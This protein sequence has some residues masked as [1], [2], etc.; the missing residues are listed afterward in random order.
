MIYLKAFKNN[1]AIQNIFLF[2]MIIAFIGSVLSFNWLTA[3]AW[4]CC[5][6]VFI[7]YCNE[8]DHNRYISN[9]LSKNYSD[10]LTNLKAANTINDKTKL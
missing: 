2:A 7:M 9:E 1:N 8:R 10:Q 4:M 3:I 6:I 5:F